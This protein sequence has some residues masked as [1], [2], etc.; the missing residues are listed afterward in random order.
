MQQTDR[1]RTIEPFGL[2]KSDM[3][4][5]SLFAQEFSP[6]YPFE[7]GDRLYWL[8]PIMSDGGRVAIMQ[9]DPVGDSICLTITRMAVFIFSVWKRQGI[10]CSWTSDQPNMKQSALPI[11]YGYQGKIV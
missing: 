5:E 10:P 3:D 9:Q 11:W 6:S 1:S 7:L 2:W 4:M 8:E